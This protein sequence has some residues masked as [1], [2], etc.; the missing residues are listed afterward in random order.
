MIRRPP[1]STLFPY[2]TLFRSDA[3]ARRGRRGGPDLRA[4]ASSRSG[5]GGAAERPVAGPRRGH[6]ACLAV[7]R[8]AAPF[9]LLRGGA[10]PRGA[11]PA[12]GPVPPPDPD[13]GHRPEHR[14]AHLSTPITLLS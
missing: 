4:R 6:R 5:G 1:R 14:T 2:T 10:A 13:P 12:Q 3:G 8:R 7:V 11:G 9:L